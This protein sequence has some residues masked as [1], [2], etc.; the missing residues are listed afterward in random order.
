MM[1]AIE[2]AQRYFDGWDRRDAD[3]IVAPIAY[4]GHL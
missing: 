1:K 3:A 2:V 4:E